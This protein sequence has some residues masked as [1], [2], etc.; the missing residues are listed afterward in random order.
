MA[1]VPT[2]GLVIEEK[3]IR[4]KIKNNPE[5]DVPLPVK[6]SPHPKRKRNGRLSILVDRETELRI[7]QTRRMLS[8]PY[9][10]KDM[11]NEQC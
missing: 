11:S 4:Y 5:Y 8:K 6:D 2:I 3:A 7:G 9:K 1:R 10:T